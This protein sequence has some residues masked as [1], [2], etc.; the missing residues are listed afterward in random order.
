MSQPIINQASRQ[1]T[2]ER[3]N[4]SVL[5]RIELA[6]KFNLVDVLPDKI[7]VTAP[8]KPSV[9][10]NLKTNSWKIEGRVMNGNINRFLEFYEELKS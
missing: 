9:E 10:F 2:Q 7:R 3:G 5:R 8:G 4:R 1:Q 6:K